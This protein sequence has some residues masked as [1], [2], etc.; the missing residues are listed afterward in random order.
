MDPKGKLDQGENQDRE[1]LLEH[2]EKEGKL[3]H[4]VNLELLEHKEK[5]DHGEKQ[6]LQVLQVHQENVVRLVGQEKE[7]SI[8]I[9]LIRLKS[10]LYIPTV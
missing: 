5:E 4:L 3:D 1:V 2:L 10:S 6:A 9:T 8:L 7:V